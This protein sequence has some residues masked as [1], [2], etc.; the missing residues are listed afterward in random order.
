MPVI[1]MQLLA[2]VAAVVLL[3]TTQASA[4]NFDFDYSSYLNTAS[5]PTED[6]AILLLGDSWAAIAGDYAANICGLSETRYVTNDAKSGTT[7][8]QWA[9]KETAVD[10]VA[11]WEYD[12]EYVWLSLG[13]NDFLD[14][15]C[16]IDMAEDVAAN[17]SSPSSVRSSRTPPTKTS[18][19]L[20]FG[21]SVP[22][23][24]VCGNGQTAQ[25]FEEQGATIFN[26]IQSSNYTEYV[27]TIDIS[28]MFVK[29]GTGGLSDSSYYYDEIHLNMLGYMHLFSSYK[30]QHFFGCSVAQTIGMKGMN[31]LVEGK[32]DPAGTV[33]AAVL[34][35]LVGIVG[36][37]LV[38]KIVKRKRAMRRSGANA[39]LLDPVEKA[40]TGGNYGT[41]PMVMVPPWKPT[42]S[43]SE[44]E[45]KPASRISTTSKFGKKIFKPRRKDKGKKAGQSVVV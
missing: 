27:T 36:L 29:W 41:A 28:E 43:M 33:I 17:I 18:K 14:N 22:S 6:G 15:K 16:D 19:I 26:A 1:N 8:S 42:S 12:Y 3:L 5:E 21:Y 4:K 25:L 45:K 30:V 9:E 23:A 35:L 13:G 39:N 31:V 20:Y 37:V 38:V 7:A 44:N 24:D 40:E 10:S 2:L 34:A 32:D 11:K